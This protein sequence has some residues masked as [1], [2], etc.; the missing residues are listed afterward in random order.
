MIVKSFK[1]IIEHLSEVIRIKTNPHSIALGFAIGT[2][3]AILPTL[4]FGVFIALVVALLYSRVNKISMF[5][6]FLVWNPLLL[7]PLY[8]LSYKLGNIFYSGFPMA[9]AESA[10]ITS[11]YNISREFFLGNFVLSSFI[12]ILSYFIIKKAAKVYRERTEL[13]EL[14]EKL[15]YGK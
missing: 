11:V 2:F 9:E 7:F 15:G 1:K 13:R 5:G 6:S 8:A 12:A 4:G 14:F 3:I 10:V